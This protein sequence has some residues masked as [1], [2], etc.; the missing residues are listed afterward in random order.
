MAYEMLEQYRPAYVDYKTALQIDCTIQL[1]ND[2]VN[3]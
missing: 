2:S 1:A 3:R